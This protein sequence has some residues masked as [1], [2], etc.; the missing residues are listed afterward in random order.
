M[1]ATSSGS[2]IRPRACIAALALS[3]R[4]LS[5]SR[6]ASG[7]RTSPGATT[8]MRTPRG[9]YVAAAD[10]ASP[11]TPAL[12][13]ATASWF[14]SPTRAAADDRRTSEP[15]PLR[16][17]AGATART[18]ANAV[19]RLVERTS[20]HSSGD[21]ACAALSKIDPQDSPHHRGECGAR[22]LR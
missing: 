14:A 4:S 17:I 13:A 18:S 8:L 7:V 3:E 1:L 15:P 20:S 6:A 5:T 10:S 16:L 12:A 2:P 19:R 9:A 22:E 11:M 21:V